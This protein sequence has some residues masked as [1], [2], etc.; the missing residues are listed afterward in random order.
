MEPNQYPFSGDARG[1]LKENI[2]EGG[3][4]RIYSNDFLQSKAVVRYKMNV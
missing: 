4:A 1:K 3:E 2:S